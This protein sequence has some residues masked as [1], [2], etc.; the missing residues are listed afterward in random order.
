MAIVTKVN[1]KVLPGQ[2]V[3][4]D[5]QYFTVT[6]AAMTQVELDSTVQVLQLYGTTE[7]VG[8]F[9]D[10]VSGTVNFIMSGV[11]PGTTAAISVA[12]GAVVA[13]ATVANMAF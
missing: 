5:F 1:G 6:K 4:R 10:G 13:G 2:F 3:G 7:A 8:A 11:A 9:V 12:V